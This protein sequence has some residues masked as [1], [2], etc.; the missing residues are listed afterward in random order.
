LGCHLNPRWCRIRWVAALSWNARCNRQKSRKR[1]QRYTTVCAWWV[2]KNILWL[3]SVSISLLLLL[4]YV[5]RLWLRSRWT[6]RFT[7]S[8]CIFLLLRL[9]SHHW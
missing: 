7:F 9:A 5:L 1:D 6:L 8:S 3:L 2:R 4:R